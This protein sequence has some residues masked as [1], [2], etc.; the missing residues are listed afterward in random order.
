MPNQIP[1]WIMDAAQDIAAN[2]AGYQTKIIGD[3][4][5]DI[6]VKISNH[7]P[8]ICAGCAEIPKS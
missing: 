3:A 7:Q 2:L 4:A 8:D 1:G 5:K 6:A